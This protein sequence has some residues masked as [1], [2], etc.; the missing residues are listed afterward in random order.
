[1]L[2]NAFSPRA[3]GQQGFSLAEVLVVVVISAIVGA[4]VHRFYRDSYRTYSMQE[5]IEERNQNANFAVSKMVELMQQVGA[6][7]PDT[8]WSSM[9][10]AG[11]VLTLGSN[12]AGVAHFVGNNPP[13]SNSVALDGAERLRKS[14]QP[15]MSSSH[16]LVDFVANT[17]TKKYQIDTTKNNNGYVKGLRIDTAG[18]DSVFLTEAVNLSVGDWL[19]GYREDQ[20]LLISDS[21]V[22][23][24]NGSA[25][26]QMVLAE[27]IDSLGFSFLDAKGNTATAW[28][29]MRSVSFVVRARTAKSDPALPKPG[30]RLISLPM[31]VILRNK[32]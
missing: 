27:N 2:Q 5:Q 19:Y 29:D 30:Y 20:Y 6:G 13:S 7:L 11:K 17:A 9:I 22:I 24:P 21:L 28:K 4:V 12:P 25:A 1:M 26:L 3:R 18:I 31:N 23:R 8:G 32:V 14:T 16:I 15:L 10:Y